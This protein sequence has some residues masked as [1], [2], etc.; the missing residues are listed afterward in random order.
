MKNVNVIMIANEKVSS[1]QNIIKE[2]HIIM[3][4]NV[5]TRAG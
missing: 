3:G 5:M 1:K 4:S 2:H